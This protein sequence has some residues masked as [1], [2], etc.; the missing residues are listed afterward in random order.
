MP[1]TEEKA[2]NNKIEQN[3]KEKIDKLK[4]EVWFYS[5]SY[6][7]YNDDN[8]SETIFSPF[9]ITFSD[10]NI[11]FCFEEKCNISS[12]KINDN[13]LII[14]TI[15]NFAGEYIVSFEEDNLV[16]DYK[17]ND[18]SRTIYYFTPAVG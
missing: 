13:I 8:M 14:D 7:Y 4:N 3:D 6:Y 10:N 12:Y 18:G 2:K 9:K 17:S 1:Y 15:Q 16:L 5:K 11:E